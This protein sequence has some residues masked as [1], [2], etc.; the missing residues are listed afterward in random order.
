MSSR[1]VI[2]SVSRVEYDDPDALDADDG[3][4]RSESEHAQLLRPSAQAERCLPEL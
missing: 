3:L 2:Q 1:V 4:Q